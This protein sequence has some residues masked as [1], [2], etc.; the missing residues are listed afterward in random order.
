MKPK[1]IHGAGVFPCQLL[2]IGFGL[3]SWGISTDAGVEPTAGVRGRDKGQPGA[4]D[5]FTAGS[6][7]RKENGGAL[8]PKFQ[9]WNLLFFCAPDRIRILKDYKEQWMNPSF[10]DPNN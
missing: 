1:A 4:E 3:G 2:K 7:L 8:P 5:E 6:R 9:T 10:S